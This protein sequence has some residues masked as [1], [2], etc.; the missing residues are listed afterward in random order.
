M[1]QHCSNALE[2][3]R[4]LEGHPR[5]ARVNY[6][7]LASHPREAPGDVDGPAAD[8]DRLAAQP[9]VGRLLD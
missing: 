3:G 4:W 6:P 1:R 7:G 8:G 5:I 2:V 9:R